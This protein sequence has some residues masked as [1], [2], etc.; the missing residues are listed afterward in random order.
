MKLALREM[1]R[2][3]G[4]FAIATVILTLIAILL[5]FLGGL[6]DGLVASSTGAFRAQ[7][8]DLMVYATSARN[9]LERHRASGA[10]AGRVC[11]R[12][13]TRRRIGQCA[14]RGSRPWT[15]PTRAR[16]DR[17]LR[18]RAG[19]ARPARHATSSRHGVR[20]HLAASEEREGRDHDPPRTCAVSRHGR[21]LRVGHSLLRSRVVVGIPR[22]VAHRAQRQPSRC[23]CRTRGGSGA[24]RQG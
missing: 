12:G 1:R 15:R 5:M 7:Q 18:L 2:Q 9:T 4:R 10:A 17:P 23:A 6:L 13:H 14:A 21:W 11:G 24:G 16:P 22:D 20:R 3:P 8:G 19:A